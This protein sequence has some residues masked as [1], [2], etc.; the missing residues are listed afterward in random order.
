MKKILSIAFFCLMLISYNAK[1]QSN[2][3]WTIND[4]MS[5]GF[6]KTATAFNSTFTGFKSAAEVTKFCQGIKAN[7]EV[8]SFDVT[9]STATSCSGKLVMKRAQN[10]PYYIGLMSKSGV[11]YISANGNKKSLDEL[12]QGKK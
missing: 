6:F 10:K 5:K 12:K 4:N 3:T 7:P 11:T 2:L 9:S 8:Q 1:S